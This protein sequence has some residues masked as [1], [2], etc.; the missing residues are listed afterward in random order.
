MGYIYEIFRILMVGQPSGVSV[1]VMISVS[2]MFRDL[3]A[4]KG[5]V[6]RLEG[7]GVDCVHADLS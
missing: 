2:S 5:V 6:R 7:A 3:G 1:L 4:A